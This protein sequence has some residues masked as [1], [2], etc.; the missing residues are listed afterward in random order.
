MP[1][2]R[3]FRASKPPSLMEHQGFESRIAGANP[4]YIHPTYGLTA[5]ATTTLTISGTQCG[6][7]DDDGTG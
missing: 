1:F 2:V 4:P 3:R 5:E 6:F 7:A